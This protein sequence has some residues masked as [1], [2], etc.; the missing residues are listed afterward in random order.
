MDPTE[1]FLMQSHPAE[2]KNSSLYFITLFDRFASLLLMNG[3]HSRQKRKNNVPASQSKCHFT[4]HILYHIQNFW[5][6]H[7]LFFWMKRAWVKNKQMQNKIGWIWRH[8]KMTEPL[9]IMAY[10][11]KAKVR[12]KPAAEVLQGM[13]MYR[14]LVIIFKIKR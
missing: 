7:S 1:W 8:E 13:F 11:K 10:Q 4:K 2:L 5:L 6:W 9:Y 3:H 14:L 12:K